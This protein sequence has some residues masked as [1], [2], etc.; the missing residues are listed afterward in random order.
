MAVSVLSDNMSQYHRRL[1]FSVD[2]MLGLAGVYKRSLC[3]KTYVRARSQI[4]TRLGLV[5]GP[6]CPYLYL[7]CISVPWIWHRLLDSRSFPCLFVCCI[8]LCT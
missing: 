6:A 2:E 1:N 5:W 3:I 8:L 4:H 7:S